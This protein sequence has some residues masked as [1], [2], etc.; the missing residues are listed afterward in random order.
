MTP[1]SARRATTS[2]DS[3]AGTRHET[4]VARSLRH[5]DVAARLARGDAET[6]RHLGRALVRPVGDGRDRGSQPG[7]SRPRRQVRVEPL[8]HRP[9]ASNVPSG[10]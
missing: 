5:D 10:S 4:S 8:Q 1:A 7:D 2:A 9:S 6:L 3:S